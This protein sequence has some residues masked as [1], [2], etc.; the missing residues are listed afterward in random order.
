M[1]EVDY[2]DHCQVVNRV[3]TKEEG[4]LLALGFVLKNLQLLQT[5]DTDHP[6]ITIDPATTTVPLGPFANNNPVK[7]FITFERYHR[8][9]ENTLATIRRAK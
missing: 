2:R 5:W 9:G 1:Y 7:I 6:R 3:L 8:S 4:V